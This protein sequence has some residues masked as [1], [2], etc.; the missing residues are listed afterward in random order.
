MVKHNGMQTAGAATPPELWGGVESTVNRVRDRYFDQ[1]Q[2]SG[3]SRRIR[4]LD[5][6]AQLGISRLRY[7]VLWERVCPEGPDIQDWGWADRRM[8][9]LRDLA[10][11][12]IVGLVH[13]G[14][15]PRYTNLL[16]P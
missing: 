14:S 12:P 1:L 7:P 15:G 13:H 4:D 16:D 8:A 2:R 5:L 11:P 9:R 10:L 6:F 3:H